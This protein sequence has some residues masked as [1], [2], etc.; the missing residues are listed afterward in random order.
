MKASGRK[1]CMSPCICAHSLHFL[2]SCD[3]H[4]SCLCSSSVLLK[5]V[6][7]LQCSSQSPACPSAVSSVFPITAGLFLSAYGCA[8]TL[9][10]FKNN[11]NQNTSQHHIFLQLL[12]KR[13]FVGGST[14]S[15]FWI[16]C[17][18]VFLFRCCNCS[19]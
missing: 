6:A 7:W 4:L 9:L 13:V 17:H 5:S 10:F 11:R 12:S 19:C 18:Q 16:H 2:L 1:L 15:P 8:E 14:H 3:C